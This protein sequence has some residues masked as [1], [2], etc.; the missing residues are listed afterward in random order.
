MKIA[1]IKKIANKEYVESEI[2]GK[3]KKVFSPRK[4]KGYE[5]NPDYMEQGI[6][7]T[8][9]TGEIIVALRDTNYGSEI[10]GQ[11]ITVSRGKTQKG[12][13]FPRMNKWTKDGEE[14]CGV[15]VPKS[16]V[17]CIGCVDG[18]AVEESSAPEKP[19]KRENVG[20]NWDDKNKKEIR[21]TICDTVFMTVYPILINKGLGDDEIWADIQRYA[22]KVFKWVY[23]VPEEV[24]DEEEIPF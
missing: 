14:R 7:V 1:E 5:S 15:K 2:V 16:C 13:V 10:E 4:M 6:V 18:E 24:V 8:D 19:E 23:E 11:N 3:V 12:L 22:D 21:K 17:V 9:E 20:T